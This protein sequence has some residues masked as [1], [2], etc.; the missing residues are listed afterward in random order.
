[1]SGEDGRSNDLG[2]RAAAM[3]AAAL[4][5]V[6]D[7]ASFGAAPTTREL[8]SAAHGRSFCVRAHRGYIECAGAAIPDL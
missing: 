2:R 5:K 1:M 3:G 4:A 7:A 8:P 6:T